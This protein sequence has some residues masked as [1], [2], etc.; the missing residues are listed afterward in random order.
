MKAPR[1]GVGINYQPEFRTLLNRSE[2]LIDFIEVSP[3][4]LCN[5][6]LNKIGQIRFNFER[7]QTALNYGSK[8]PV[9]V[10]GL[11]LSIGS[12]S[13]WNEDYI[14]LLDRFNELQRFYW[15]SEHLGFLHIQ[16]PSGELE[17]AGVQL[18]MPFTSEAL[19]L[20]I[21]RIDFLCHRY[22]KPFLIE[23][24]TYYLPDM[25][26][27]IGMDE[28]VFLNRLTEKTSCGLLLDLHNYY[29]NAVNFGFDPI[30]GLSRLNMDKVAEIHIAGGTAYSP[31]GINQDNTDVSARQFLLD[32]HSDVVPEPVWDLLD[33]T[34]KRAPNVS[35]IVYEL[36]EQ[37]HNIVDDEKIGRQLMR[38]KDLWNSHL[39][40]K[41]EALQ[42]R[43]D[44]APA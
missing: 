37:A 18:P 42:G 7:L 36:L 9:V 44:H 15:H 8:F 21:P 38:A 14:T 31:G 13:G 4:I 43:T 32:I 33:W 3:D 1:L 26:N 27:D 34:L 20:L 25:P 22:D 5:E 23:N 29:C 35:A 6:N 2:E 40:E 11:G 12:A 30:E 17:H 41:T 16:R 39:G 24:T 19:E 10:H 28:I